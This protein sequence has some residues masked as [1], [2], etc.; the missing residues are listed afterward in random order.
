MKTLDRS[1]EMLGAASFYAIHYLHNPIIH[2]F[3]PRKILHNHC[4]QVL[5]VLRKIKNNAYAYFC[6]VKE[7]Y[8]GICASSE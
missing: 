1:V 7:V 3:Y 4:L 8:Y 5:L 6:W 2:L